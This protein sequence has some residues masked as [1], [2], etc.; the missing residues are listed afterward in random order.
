MRLSDVFWMAV[1]TLNRRLMILPAVAIAISTFCLCFAGAVLTNVQLEKSLPYELEVTANAAKLSESTLAGIS[2]IPGVT[3]VTPVL[4][5]PASIVT[6]QYK[7]QLTLAGIDAAYIDEDFA[8]GGVFSDSSVMPYIVLNYAACKLFQDEKGSGKSTEDTDEPLIDWLSASVTIQ[9][10]EGSKPV[11][12]KIVGLLIGDDEDQEPVA[13]MSVASAKNLLSQD[14][15]RVDYMSA[16]VRVENVGYAADVS[17]ELKKQGL[18]VLN[19]NEDSE[20][21]W[22]MDFKDLN[23][24][25]LLGISCLVIALV[26]SYSQIKML[27]FG[28]K[29]ELAA[30]QWIGLKQKDSRRIYSIQSMVIAL[31]GIAIGIVVSVFIPSFLSP[32]AQK[33]T[34]FFLQIPFTIIAICAAVCMMVYVV[35]TYL[36]RIKMK[37]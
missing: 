2:G 16:K 10:S 32:D 18:S 14:G 17:K 1:K 25:A 36:W 7:A 8:Q 4:E 5:V 20:L 11:V 3:A 28:K 15:Q 21:K 31:L 24:L 29:E 27:R 34:I 13:Y 33:T 9:T 19:A 35:P 30:L 26:F 37:A 22:D 12:S 6:G 23:Y